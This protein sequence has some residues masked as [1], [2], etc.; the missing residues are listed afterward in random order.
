MVVTLG[1]NSLR[2]V[3]AFPL[4]SIFSEYVPGLTMIMSPFV[5]AL[6]AS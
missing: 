5:A 6:M 1:L 2:K 4:K 3:I